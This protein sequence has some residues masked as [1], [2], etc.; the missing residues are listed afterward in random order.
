MNKATWIL[1]LLVIIVALGGAYFFS[2]RQDQPPAP[3]SGATGNATVGATGV[4]AIITYTDT[5]FSPSPQTIAPG[6]TVTWVNQSS[7]LMWIES[8]A[9]RGNGCAHPG[10]TLDQC[11]GV[12]KGGTYSHTFT[13]LGTFAYLNHAKLSDEGVIMVTNASSSGPINPNALPE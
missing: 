10:S 3:D 12:A 5:G 8:S 1:G 2:I 13:A 9:G 7:H 11:Q 6:T 4:S